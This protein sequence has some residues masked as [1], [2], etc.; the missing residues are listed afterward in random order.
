MRG[1]PSIH[2]PSHPRP[3]R[4][5]CCCCRPCSC[6]W[7]SRTGRSSRTLS[8]QLP[9]DAQGRPRRRCWWASRTTRSWSTTRCS[10][11]RSRTTCGSPARTIPL[12]IGLALADGAVGQR[13]HRRARLAAHGVLHA[14]RAA[15]DRGGQHLAV[16][17]HAAV[18][19]AGAGRAARSACAS[20][21]WLG[22]QGTALGAVTLVAVW[23]EAGF[24]MIFYLAALQSLNPSLG[25]AAAIEGASRWYLLPAR[26]VAAADA[27]HAV[28]ADQRRDQRLPH[29]RPHLRADARRAGQ[30]VHAAAV[31]PLRGRLQLLGHRPMRPRSP[32]CCSSCWSALA[33]LQFFV[34]D[35][36]RTTDE[37]R[38][39]ATPRPA[40]RRRLARHRWPPGCWRCCGCCRWPTP[41]WTA[42]HAAEYSS[43][44]R[45]GSRRSRW[46]TSRRAWEAA[47]FARYF[48]NT[49]AAGHDD[50]GRAAGAVHAGGLCLRALR[51]P[52][53]RRRLRAGA[54][55]A[56][57]HA[58]PAAG[59]ELPHHGQP[60][61]DRQP[62]R[63]RPALLRLGASPSSCCARPSWAS[64]RSSTRPRASRA[65]AP[66][67]CCGAST[68]RWRGR[69]TSPSALVSVSFHWNNFLWP[70][71]V[72]NSVRR[73]AAHRGPAGV[74]VGR[75]G[76]RLVD[77]HGRHAD[78][79]GAAADR[80]PAVPAP[81]RPELH[82]RRASSETRHLEHPVVPRPRRHA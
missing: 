59:R 32:W 48:L 9:V 60:G 21:N 22:S 15:D 82:A 47:P 29:G 28:R 80:L 14:D 45:P 51:V 50:P 65:R 17:L 56:D 66:C 76:R 41:S 4:R 68:C 58:G 57:D 72:T 71:I 30:R 39:V 70:L 2:R 43:A 36:G 31:L 75:P 55:A 13:A 54:G 5:G 73:A 23:K 19:P 6:C 7:P 20:H 62:V 26:A 46:T 77:H 40:T 79:L 63:H 33:L 12:S 52:R 34:L 1:S 69:S 8:A 44:L 74:L 64:R 38:P 3:A 67:R 35:S 81:V 11:R 49:I 10:G 25:E 78:D 53:P 42:F 27:D 61:P 16:L 18:R 37:P 24:F